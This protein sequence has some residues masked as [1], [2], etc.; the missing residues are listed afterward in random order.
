[1]S[2]MRARAWLAAAGVFCGGVGACSIVI[3]ALWFARHPLQDWMVYYGA[4]RAYLAGNLPLIFDGERFTAYL[5]QHFAG[6][7]AAPIGFRSWV[8]PPTFLL[9]IV[10]FGLF[11]FVASCAVFE[12]VTFAGLVAAVW[13]CVGRG[14]DRVLHV[15][16]LLLAPAVWFNLATGQNGLLSA[17]LLIGGF[18]ALPRRPALAGLLLGLLSYKPQLW[19]LVPVALA[20]ARQWRVLASAVLTAALLALAS[21]AVFGSTAWLTWI[22]WVVNP[23]PAAY[24]A[25]L[26]CCRLHDESVYTNLALLGAPRL[27]A[28]LGQLAA[29]GVAGGC[30]WWGWRRPLQAE[31]QLAVLLA[32][33]C[34]A[35]PHVANYDAVLLVV[36]A[37]LVFVHGLGHGFRPAGAI[38]PLLVWAIQLANPPDVFPIGRLTPL[39]TLLLI[40]GALAAA[41][42]DRHVDAG[43]SYVS[44]GQ[45]AV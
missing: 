41:S 34:L 24:Q 7:L 31:L 27:A 43:L 22:G 8:Y 45:H 10:P 21:L 14:G 29:I 39:L 40:A 15:L 36:A 20:A 13:Q 3:Y 37:T 32:A 11:G 18:G 4:I 1:M 25:F 12:A 17:G 28:D 9:L 38:V 2:A 33:T 6:W 23:P 16:S 42:G 35:A 30:V 26:E 5:N 44:R 19:L